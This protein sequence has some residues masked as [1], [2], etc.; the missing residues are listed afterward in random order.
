MARKQELP[1]KQILSD[2]LKL[3]ARTELTEKQIKEYL[4]AIY[5]CAPVTIG[6]WIPKA[7]EVSLYS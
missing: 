1:K 3:Y 7:E 2:Y 6:C 5:N 4:A